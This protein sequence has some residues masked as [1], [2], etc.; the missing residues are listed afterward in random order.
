[1]FQSSIDLNSIRGFQMNMKTPKSVT[2]LPITDPKFIENPY[3]FFEKRRQELAGDEIGLV[4]QGQYSIVGFDLG[5]KMLRNNKF[6]R[7]DLKSNPMAQKMIALNPF[8]EVTTEWMLMR[9]E[10]DHGRLRKLVNKAFTPKTVK[11]LI[12]KIETI[13]EDLISPIKRNE[14]FDLID[15][16]AYRLPVTVISEMLGIPKEDQHLFRDWSKKFVISLDNRQPTPQELTEINKAAVEMRDYLNKLIVEIKSTGSDRGDII[17]KL[18]E[19]EEDGDKLTQ[20]E[21][22][23]NIILLYVAGHET[24]S[25][26]IANG[27]NALIDYP[28]QINALVSDTNAIPNAVEEFLR[29]D[30]PVQNTGRLILETFDFEDYEVKAGNFISI[31]IGA[32]NRDPKVYENPN[33][34]DVFRKNVKHLSFGQGIHFCLGA[35]LARAEGRIFFKHF[36]TNFSEFRRGSGTTIRQMNSLLRGFTRFSISV[37]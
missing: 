35:P 10:P 27:L 26:L 29:F 28:E 31:I 16:L 17:S 18:I 8:M 21:V 36:L 4:N 13:V 11:E 23:S 6:G 20:S 2:P 30:P 3:Q 22:V 14:D 7:Q 34:L 37:S 12:P 25:N 1:M 5:T 33:Q 19:A 24:T 32:A 15:K 9:N